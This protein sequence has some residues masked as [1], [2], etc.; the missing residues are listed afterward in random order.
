MSLR[1]EAAITGIGELK[2][3]KGPAGKTSAGLAAEAAKH[4]IEDAGLKREEVDGL[5]LTHSLW[6]LSILL[7]EQL[8]EYM[9][10]TPA[11]AD[12]M[13]VG[14]ASGAAMV[15]RAAAAVKAGV[16]KNVLCVCGDALNV[17]RFYEGP[18]RMGPLQAEFERPY[19]VMPANCAFAM[20]ARR[21]MHEYGTTREQIAQVAV[22]QRANA[23]L[24]PDAIFHGQPISVDDVLKSPL[25]ADPL[26]RLDMVMPVSGAAAYIVTAADRAGDALHP[27]VYLLGC[28]EYVTH[29][30]ISQAPTLTKSPATVSAKRA[31]EMAG[32][33]PGDIDHVGLYDCY[34]IT[35]IV[36]LEDVGFCP[37]GEGGSFV[38]E[39][40][41]SPTGKLP[42]NTHGGEL[43]FGQAGHSGGMSFV[44]EAVQQLR[45][46]AGQRQVPN[47]ELAFINGNG[48]F[49]SIQTSLV[50]GR[51]R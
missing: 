32:V 7:P 46:E 18:R 42:L 3:M 49:L 39:M 44:V 22:K 41:T 1:G 27:P 40:D 35:V 34:T 20:I 11:Y 16:C 48:G 23:C 10:I 19:T 15:W 51:S 30:I 47:C 4:A 29:N 38:A 8:A 28:G 13:D 31:F 5:L 25:V 24:H 2:P 36:E 17:S 45:G 33:T 43:S 12:T 21:H 50:L 14:G 37:K 9:K 6:D 26:H